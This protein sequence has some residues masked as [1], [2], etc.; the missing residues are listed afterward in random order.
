MKKHSP[1][2][3]SITWLAFTALIIALPACKNLLLKPASASDPVKLSA[4][5]PA[6]KSEQPAAV[7]PGVTTRNTTEIPDSVTTPPMLTDITPVNEIPLFSPP[8]ENE[9][10]LWKRIEVGMKLRGYETNPRVIAQIKWFASHQEY[11]N[12]VADRAEPFLHLIM[13]QVENNN[14]PAEIALLPVVESAFQPF[15][16]SHGRAAGLWQFIPGTG[17][18]YGL[19][20]NWWYD[21][22]RDVVASTKAALKYLGALH[23]R[24]KGDWL[25]ALAA[26]NSG[27]GNIVHAIRKNKRK[28]RPVDFWHLGLSKET[29]AYVPKLLAISEII[30]N[31]LKYNIILNPIANEPKV[32]EVKVNS[33]IDL[34]LVARLAEVSLED[35][36]R[37]NPAFNHWATTPNREH[38]LLVPV[39]KES[40][41]NEQLAKTPKNKRIQW[42]RHKIKSGETLSHIAIKYGTTVRLLKQVNKVRGYAIRKGRHLLIPVATRTLS[43]Y[44]LT[45]NQRSRSRL[46]QTR[47][48]QKTFHIV[49]MGD[50]FWDLSMKYKVPV[51]K[52]AK[53][54]GMAPRDILNPGKK[55]VLWTKNRQPAAINRI[56]TRPAALTIRTIHYTVK[57]GDS[58]ARISARFRVTINQLRKWNGL[59]KGKYLQ[60]GQRLTLHV[61]VTRQ[62]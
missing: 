41:F 55:L 30:A 39:E 48:G 56:H 57:R 37:L 5:I 59:I 31:P 27:E 47:P 42:K 24:F 62:T 9:H 19:K 60:P 2:R 3:N 28:G 13:E 35:V 22:R 58:L 6:K 46:N 54:N 51:R 18:L 61:D 38:M 11:L 25:L 8:Y 20:Q 1:I 45:K 36:Y 50:T 49:R 21:G 15:A 34:A 43:H 26:Y 53:W 29:R 4:D 12:R 40:I 44:S 17:R 16:Y 14:M 52:L 10:S 7:Q 33:Q 23:K 32:A